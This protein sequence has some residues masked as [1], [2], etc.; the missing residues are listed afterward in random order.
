MVGPSTLRFST[1]APLV[2]I[3]ALSSKPSSFAVAYGT[4]VDLWDLDERGW[5]EAACSIV[6]RDL[7]IREWAD[8]SEQG[9]PPSICAKAATGASQDLGDPPADP[10]GSGS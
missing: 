1:L 3:A 10:T 7:T 5:I 6:G 9:H 4:A 8:T 2:A